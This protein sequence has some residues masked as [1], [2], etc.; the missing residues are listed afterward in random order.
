MENYG[1]QP[2]RISIVPSSQQGIFDTLYNDHYDA[3]GQSII[4]HNTRFMRVGDENGDNSSLERAAGFA[5]RAGRAGWI[6][7]T[8]PPGCFR[9]H[10]RQIRQNR[11][12]PGRHNPQDRAARRTGIFGTTGITPI[13]AAIGTPLG[14][15]TVPRIRQLLPNRKRILAGRTRNRLSI[16]PRLAGPGRDK[17]AV[18]GKSARSTGA[19]ACA[20]RFKADAA[21][22]PLASRW[23]AAARPHSRGASNGRQRRQD[24]REGTPGASPGHAKGVQTAKL[25]A[26]S[27]ARSSSARSNRGKTRQSA[28]FGLLR[29]CL[30]VVLG[31]YWGGT[32]GVVAGVVAGAVAGVVAG[33]LPVNSGRYRAVCGRLT[34]RFVAGLR[35]GLRPVCWASVRRLVRQSLPENNFA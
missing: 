21:R 3:C 1:C 4:I 6:K 25:A 5:G 8:V 18:F 7:E 10:N 31:R 23:Q 32:P 28:L 30:R 15:S 19:T 11:H 16:S 9:R 33:P 26:R 20:L 22:P 12:P 17:R 34:G 27:S 35:A 13:I 2:A 14:C 29:G 24:R